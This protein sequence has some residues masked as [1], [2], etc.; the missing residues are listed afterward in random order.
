MRVYNLENVIQ[1]YAW[2]SSE[3]MG[4]YFALSNAGCAPMAEV[5]MGA[6][7]SA[8]SK[9]IYQGEK[10]DLNTVI[11]KYT[12]DFLGDICRTKYDN[13]LPFL[14]K[15]LAAGRPLSIQAHPNKKQAESGFESENRMGIDLTARNRNYRDTNHK[16]EIISAVSSFRALCGFRKADSI[17]KYAKMIDNSFYT[18]LCEDLYANKD[19]RVFFRRLMSLEVKQ[20]RAL[21]NGAARW[22]LKKNTEEQKWIDRL[23][24]IYPDDIAILSP[25]YLNLIELE[26][27]EALYL[28]AGI[29]HA[30][31]S[32]IGIELMANSDN[33]LRGGLTEK[34]I[35]LDELERI[36]RFEC[37]NPEILKP[38][39]DDGSY[40]TPAGEFRLSKITV[41]DEP[42]KIHFDC[43][44]IFLGYDGNHRIKTGDGNMTIGKGQSI[45]VCPDQDIMLEGKGTVFLAG[46]PQGRV[47][48]A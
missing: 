27:G 31:L 3:L 7:P 34:H 29:L 11:S 39:M 17:L 1:T 44:G 28:D 2:G 14:F 32:G 12:A 45:F 46:V 40:Y 22:A 15:I 42:L 33:V 21:I 20:K 30:Y 38:D 6:H 16:P 25:V 23:A 9:L 5:W 8:P 35:D 41:G 48:N 4:E 13:M 37:V 26:P 19:Y 10:T 43:P 18:E 36:L 47:K 24:G